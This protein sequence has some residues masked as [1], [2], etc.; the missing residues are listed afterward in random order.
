MIVLA[1]TLQVGN[2]MNVKFLAK[3][4]HNLVRSHNLK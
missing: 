3:V 1:K 2:Y 4:E